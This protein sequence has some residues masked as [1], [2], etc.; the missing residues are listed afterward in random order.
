MT[1]KN[2]IL[3]E[4]IELE[5]EKSDCKVAARFIIL[6]HEL[7]KLYAALGKISYEEISSILESVSK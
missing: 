1:I 7:N 6:E 5:Q 3:Q 4:I 2:I